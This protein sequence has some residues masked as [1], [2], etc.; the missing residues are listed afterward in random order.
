MEKVYCF[1]CGTKLRLE[2][3]KELKKTYKYYCPECDENMFYFE[4]VNKKPM[5]GE[6]N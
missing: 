3:N 5:S 1:R 2:K 6:V 4:A